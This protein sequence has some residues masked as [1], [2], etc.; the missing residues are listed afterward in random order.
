MRRDEEMEKGLIS[1]ALRPAERSKLDRLIASKLA[2]A[3]LSRPLEKICHAIEA[4]MALDEEKK[5]L[6]NLSEEEEKEINKIYTIVI[7]LLNAR[8]Y[9][10]TRDDMEYVEISW[11]FSEDEVPCYFSPW[12]KIKKTFWYWHHE[13]LNERLKALEDRLVERGL[14]RDIAKL[15]STAYLVLQVPECSFLINYLII[16]N[17]FIIY[18]VPKVEKLMG[19]IFKYAIDPEVWDYTLSLMGGKYVERS[20]QAE[21]NNFSM[22]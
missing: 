5:N 9:I 4:Y 21:K 7:A 2:A 13:G 14:K 11:P 20:L 12:L 15:Y 16:V 1:K 10:R 8:K 22:G 17:Q 19:M 6:I 3:L 18:A